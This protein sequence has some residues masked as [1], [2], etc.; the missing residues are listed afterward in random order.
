MTIQGD[1]I[2]TNCNEGPARNLLCNPC[3]GVTS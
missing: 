3:H 2:Q 1:W